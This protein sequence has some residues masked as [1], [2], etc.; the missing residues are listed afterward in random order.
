LE[1]NVPFQHKFFVPVAYV[2]G[3]V[4]LRHVDD[5]PHRLSGEGGDESAQ[6]GRSVI[7]DCLVLFCY[8]RIVSGQWAICKMRTSGVKWHVLHPDNLPVTQPT[9]SR[10]LLIISTKIE[11]R[12]QQP[13]M[14]STMTNR[15][16]Q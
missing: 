10:H 6:H 9:V 12:K 16:T 13:F 3:S 11:F 1:F 8:T 5:R 14:F 2:R 4:L 7:Y 15:H